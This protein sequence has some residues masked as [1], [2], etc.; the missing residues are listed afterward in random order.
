MCF[1]FNPTSPTLDDSDRETLAESLLGMAAQV[2]RD[3]Q[4]VKNA[5]LDAARRGNTAFIERI[6]RSWMHD[7][8]ANVVALISNDSPRERLDQR[9]PPGSSSSSHH[10]P[11]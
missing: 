7:P 2:E 1:E 8:P 4:A 11:T 5:I 10:R 6:V 3:E 9:P